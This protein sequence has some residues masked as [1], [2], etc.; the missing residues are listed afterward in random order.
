M[1]RIAN[2]KAM[3]ICN[4]HEPTLDQKLQKSMSC[5]RTE[6]RKLVANLKENNDINERMSVPNN[7][8]KSLGKWWLN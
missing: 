8:Y 5:Q 6:E 1:K 4:S 3:H 7:V 2:P